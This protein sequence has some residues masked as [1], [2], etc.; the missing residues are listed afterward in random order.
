[1]K[2]LFNKKK[3]T[4]TAFSIPLTAAPQKH[5]HVEMGWRR[6]F[7]SDSSAKNKL[8]N[9]INLPSALQNKEDGNQNT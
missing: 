9:K 6:E 5:Q 1:M 2:K 8:L 4:G 3:K 7:P